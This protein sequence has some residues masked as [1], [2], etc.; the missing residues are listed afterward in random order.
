MEVDY[1]T[2]G[3]LRVPVEKQMR[4]LWTEFTDLRNL[5]NGINEFVGS[6][7]DRLSRLEEDLDHDMFALPK[8]PE[9]AVWI[10]KYCRTVMGWGI[11]VC[12]NCGEVSP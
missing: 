7:D 1:R 11:K 8:H 9:N 6:I 10:C 12:N 3:G 4:Q 5:V 2:A